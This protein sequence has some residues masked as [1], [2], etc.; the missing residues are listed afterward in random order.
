MNGFWYFGLNCTNHA[1]LDSKS[2]A[3][4]QLLEWLPIDWF[5]DHAVTLRQ[6]STGFPLP[7]RWQP[8]WQTV[9][10]AIAWPGSTGR[11][12]INPK[13]NCCYFQYH[14]FND[15]I[16]NINYIC[17]GSVFS[18]VPQKNPSTIKEW[19]PSSHAVVIGHPFWF[20]AGKSHNGSPDGIQIIGWNTNV[21]SNWMHQ[22][23]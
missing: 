23:L 1:F 14:R 16:R 20:L 18:V 19:F 7:T 8:W 13:L 15:V 5:W 4:W 21:S 10:C 22:W 11:F 6:S 3:P 2:K 9:L 17:L 12:R